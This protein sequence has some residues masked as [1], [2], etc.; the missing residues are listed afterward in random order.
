[1]RS[2]LPAGPEELLW[3]EVLSTILD[4]PQGWGS[5]AAHVL[6]GERPAKEAKVSEWSHPLVV[7]RRFCALAL[8]QKAFRGC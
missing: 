6:P 7:K 3:S 4:E 2:S 5:Q 8:L 1:M